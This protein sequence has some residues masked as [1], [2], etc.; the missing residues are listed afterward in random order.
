MQAAEG[1]N[2]RS[3]A[4]A[5]CGRLLCSEAASVAGQQG[6][7]QGVRAA[8]RERQGGYEP[9]QAGERAGGQPPCRSGRLSLRQQ[10]PRQK[11]EASQAEEQEDVGERSGLAAEKESQEA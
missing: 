9:A 11:A 10:R 7:D 1:E 2:V 3:A 6:G 5:E 4:G 8:V